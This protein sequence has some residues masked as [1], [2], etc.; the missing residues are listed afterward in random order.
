MGP[1]G[2]CAA[3][4]ARRWPAS[5]L[6]GWLARGRRRPGSSGSGGGLKSHQRGSRTELKGAHSAAPPCWWQNLKLNS[7]ESL[8]CIRQA[9]GPASALVLPEAR[10]QCLAS[11]RPARLSPLA[12]E[13]PSSARCKF[14]QVDNRILMPANQTKPTSQLACQIARKEP[15]GPLGGSREPLE[16]PERTCGLAGQVGGLLIAPARA[17]PGRIISAT[18]LEPPQW[19]DNRHSSRRRHLKSAYFASPSRLASSR[20][21]SELSRPFRLTSIGADRRSR[22][23]PERQGGESSCG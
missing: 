9:L 3:G 7:R 4:R 1:I 6:R 11:R 5:R 12:R 19:G 18:S 8:I 21:G 22:A 20:L 13:A 23:R 2:L 17:Q 10:S 14:H 16:G 15:S